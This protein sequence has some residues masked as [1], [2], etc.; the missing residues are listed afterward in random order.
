[1]GSL[2]VPH[3]PQP[4]IYV[5]DEGKQSTGTGLRGQVLRFFT[6]SQSTD[7]VFSVR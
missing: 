5:V 6:D 3:A 4:T 1:M 2:D 7:G